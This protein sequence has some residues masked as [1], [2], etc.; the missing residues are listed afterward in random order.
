MSF[1]ALWPI[2]HGMIDKVKDSST[3]LWCYRN[4]LASS[5]EITVQFVKRVSHLN[6]PCI[7]GFF[8]HFVHTFCYRLDKTVRH[9]TPAPFRAKLSTSPTR[10]SCEGLPTPRPAGKRKL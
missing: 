8:Q 5:I 9:S 7:S 3:E 4:W 2:M 6:T 10:R 1:I